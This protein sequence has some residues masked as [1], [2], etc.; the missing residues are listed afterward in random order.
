MHYQKLSPGP[1]K[2][3]EAGVCI[4]VVKELGGEIPMLGVCL[5]H[6]SI[7]EAYGGTMAY[8]FTRN[9]S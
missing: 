9:L 8:S 2:P 5:G 7:C 6:Q 4:P 3:S 1:G